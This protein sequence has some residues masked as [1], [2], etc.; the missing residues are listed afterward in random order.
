[1]IGR[2]ASR[3]ASAIAFGHWLA[4]LVHAGRRAP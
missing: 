1:M 4:M 2:L 3:A